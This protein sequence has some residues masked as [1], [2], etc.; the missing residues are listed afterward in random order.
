MRGERMELGKKPYE[1]SIWDDVWSEKGYY[2]EQ[3]VCNIGSNNM[4]TPIRA[5][6]PKMVSNI[7][8]SNTFTFDLNFRY[9]DDN[10]GEFVE[11]PFVSLLYNER[12]IK[13][14]EG[15]PPNAKWYDLIIKD[16][17]EN[18]EKKVFTY[19]AKDQYIN[20]LSK[21]GYELVFD[22]QLENSIGTVNELASRVLEG[23]DWKVKTTKI[24][25]GKEKDIAIF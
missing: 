21:T 7:N 9:W 3:K 20:E 16:V 11:N 6:N 2:E 23:S 17:T 22:D 4:T 12:K 25:D 10:L 15:T 8:G 24:E 19:T 18:S 1:I 13:V 14:R 5:F